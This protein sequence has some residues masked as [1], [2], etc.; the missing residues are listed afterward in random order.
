MSALLPTSADELA[1]M[2]ADASAT[3]RKVRICGLGTRRRL[4]TTPPADCLHVSLR[5]MRRI[6]RLEPDD[7]TCSVE[8]GTPCAEL[9]ARLDEAKLELGGLD[10]ADP[11]TIGGLYAAD[12]LPLPTP[13]APC[14]RST[15]LGLDAVLGD[16]T[17]FRSGARVVK[18]VAG[19]DVHRLL[20][21]SRGRM[22]A[23]ALLHL[24][25]RPK[26]QAQ[27][28]CAS[29]PLA[30]DAALARFLDLRNGALAPQQL[31]LHRNDGALHVTAVIAGRD[32]QVRRRLEQA[33]MQ[34]TAAPTRNRLDDPADGCELV[35]GAVRPSRILALLA[36]L[37]ADAP[38]L[39]HGGGTFEA[40]LRPT[41]SDRLLAALPGLDAVGA[42][43]LGAAPRVGT[44]SAQDP[45]SQRLESDLEE[46]L[47]P[48][49]TLA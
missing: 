5:A 18:S 19:F 3:G 31:L 6:E 27:V 34:A 13:G 23:A 2:L 38:A 48:R 11:G 4:L 42:I 43:A 40:L 33:S 36:A 39:V 26:P 35:V 47:D 44:A 15:L 21:G 10:A 17:H 28:A 14:Q 45:A 30:P 25:L 16:G 24:K 12:P 22:F 32:G 20:I 37:P 1:A 29:G 7:L 8:P 9:A 41:E 49:R 46:A